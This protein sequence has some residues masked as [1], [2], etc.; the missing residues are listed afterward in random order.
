MRNTQGFITV[1]FLF[2]FVLVMGFSAILFALSMTLVAVE[3]AQYATFASARAFHGAHVNNIEQ[4][5]L[6]SQKY[7]EVLSQP[8]IRPLFSNGWFVLS[9]PQIGD[10]VFAQTF[11]NYRQDPRDPFLFIG[12]GAEF[13]ARILN[14]QIPFYGSTTAVDQG[15]AGFTT[16]VSS[17][18]GREP[19]ATEC[20]NFSVNRWKAIRQLKVTN[21]APYTLNT[22]ENGYITIMDDGC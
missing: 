17:F 8:A 7:N 9:D 5:R 18:L 4:H 12:V 20:R 14:F 6:A 13:Q 15:D 22:S 19:S 11:P 21:A 3:V 16:V 1:D 2:A 10:E